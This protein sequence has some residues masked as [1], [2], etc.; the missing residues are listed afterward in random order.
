MLTRRLYVLS[1]IFLQLL[2]CNR[3]AFRSLIKC[4]RLISMCSDG[5]SIGDKIVDH[6]PCLKW[7]ES[8]L[9][10]FSNSRGFL[11]CC[12]SSCCWLY[13]RWVCNKMKREKTLNILLTCA[14]SS[15]RW[16]EY[17]RIFPLPILAL[18]LANYYNIKCVGHARVFVTIISIIPNKVS[19]GGKNI[20]TTM[21]RL[22]FLV[23]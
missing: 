11:F 14:R 15:R 13:F 8:V 10:R 1:K 23:Q 19:Q 18:S 12:C 7:M 20:G 3:R 6:H 21:R 17:V 4:Q 22:Q 5:Y 16:W 2:M 9:K